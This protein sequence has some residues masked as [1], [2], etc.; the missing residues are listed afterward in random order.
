MSKL[1][2]QVFGE[3]I[4]TVDFDGQVR[5][6]RLKRHGEHLMIKKICGWAIAY[7]DGSVHESS[8]VKKWF[9]R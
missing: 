7:P 3:P 5:K 2:R 1:F 4:W 8:Y 9:S 6:S